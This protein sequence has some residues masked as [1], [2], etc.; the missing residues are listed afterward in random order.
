M[1]ENTK[2][3]LLSPAKN[4]DCGI[5]AVN[6][7]A[8]AVYIGGPAFG[9]RQAAGN[10]VEEIGK[11][12]A[13]AHRFNARV[14]AA[15]NTILYDDELA[16]AEKLAWRLY[17]A[18]VDALIVQD[19]G[20]LELNLPPIGLH[21]S[22]QCDNRTPEKAAFLESV[23]FSQIV[24]ARELALDEIRA[25]AGATRAKLEFFI[26]GA[27]CVSF[28]GQCYLSQALYK[29]SA[30]RGEC[31]QPCRMPVTLPG[32]K[33]P[34]GY[35][36]CLKD[37]DQTQNLGALIEAGITSFKIEGRLKEID[38][39]KNVTAHYRQALD[40]LISENPHYSK[41]SSGQVRFFFKPDPERTFNRGG[42][43]YFLK[44]RNKGIFSFQTPKS[45][46]ARVA[47]VKKVGPDHLEV[48]AE[49]VFANGDGICYFDEK[50]ELKGLRVNRAEKGR[51]YPAVPYTAPSVGTVLYRNH[52]EA[53]NSLLKGVTAERS[54]GVHALLEAGESLLRLTYSDEEGNTGSAS[55]EFAP[56]PAKNS[57][58]ASETIT[59]QLG[60][61]GD[62]DFNL[63]S[64]KVDA[65]F[66][67][68]LPQSVLNSLR[69]D[70]AGKLL[71][72]RDKTRP[73]ET[74]LEPSAEPVKYPESALSCLGNVSNR[75]ARAFYAK[76]GVTDIDPAY[77]LSQGGAEAPLMTMR[78]CLAFALGNCPRENPGTKPSPEAVKI[79]GETLNVAYDC[80]TCTVKLYRQA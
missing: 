17:E 53:F 44:G 24:L 50:G 22:T 18:G 34:S 71:E 11:L 16:Q 8:D 73:L 48:A 75:A 62:T 29:R 59:T 20:L 61:L 30:N 25:I 7:G 28:S 10:S 13:Y 23:G 66:T 68:F 15:L 49:T 60:R 69:R 47:V 42:T 14:Y 21:A 57:A 32:M 27:L 1:T 45:M 54:I 70:A 9:A 67:P 3:E 2:L 55:C 43:D 26:H 36:L 6:H 33:N 38:Y 37:M 4:P 79:G 46:G 74:R 40:S 64:V 58:R 65:P 80:K 77:E 78:H 31:A 12:A 52:D 51:L 35:L 63:L 76:H 41:S 56:E 5:A 39:V 19:M 72:A